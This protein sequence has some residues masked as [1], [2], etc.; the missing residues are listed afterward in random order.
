MSDQLAEATIVSSE[1]ADTLAGWAPRSGEATSGLLERQSLSDSEQA[2]VREQ[3]LKI[4]ARCGDPSNT[5]PRRAAHLVVGEVQSGKTLSFT[6]AIAL[7]RDNDFPL[8]VVLGGTKRNL[9]G[10]TAK[11]FEADLGGND[12]RAPA[13]RTFVAGE[14]ELSDLRTALRASADLGVPKQH[15]STVVVF[16]LKHTARLGLLAAD[17]ED[18]IADAGHVPTLIIDDEADQA[19]MNVAPPGKESPVYVAIAAC[20]ES[21]RAATSSCTRPRRR[22]RC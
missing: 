22:R 9:L 14:Y 15:R 21:F 5:G 6:T 1:D 4:L 2:M 19:G 18:V 7:A 10:Q 17:L 11:R 16:V 20:D 8:V 12:G 3:A 13:F